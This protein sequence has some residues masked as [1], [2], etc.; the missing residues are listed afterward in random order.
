MFETIVSKIIEA[1]EP[2]VKEWVREAHKEGYKEGYED[3]SRR[4]LF[5]F[6]TGW[7]NG[8]VEAYVDSGAIE[9][10]EVDKELEQTVFEGVSA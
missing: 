7:K 5:A 8:Y 3:A 1:F 4:M 10:P 6:N 2:K 9:I